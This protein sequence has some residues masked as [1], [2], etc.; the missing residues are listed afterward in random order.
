MAA[1]SAR[2]A[3]ARFVGGCVRDGLIGRPI[4][5][6]D[7]ATTDTP[8]TVLALLATAGIKA[9]PTGVEHGTV[10]AVIGATHVEITTLRHDVET[11]GR[12][13]RV[14]YTD[15]WEADA[16]RR[17]FTINALYADSDGTLYDPFG[18]ADDLREGRVRFVGTAEER[19]REDVLRLL[20]FFRFHAHYGR[21]APDPDGLAACRRLAH[22]LP[23]LSGERVAGEI[24]KILSAPD[25][26]A[27][28]TLMEETGVLVHIL[29]E[30]RALGRLATLGSI[31]DAV[32]AAGP[33][34]RLAVLIEGGTDAADAVATRLRL[35]NEQRA[36][37]VGMVETTPPI[38]RDLDRRH[39]RRILYRIGA[40][41]FRDRVLFAWADS[42]SR[43]ASA[44]E[45]DGWTRL[46]AEADAW[47]P[48][49]LPVKGRDVVALGVER[50]PE[51]GRL[52]EALESWWLDGDMRAG[53]E[54]ALAHLRSLVASSR[55]KGGR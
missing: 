27:I 10:T 44:S 7:L 36:R 3:T 39:V 29:P 22:L 38:H 2:G 11:F 4:G 33:L 17:D 41:R 53:R 46:L 45:T 32:G 5:D 19:I 20:R 30:A 6:V 13:A 25:V 16:A 1:L 55:G 12:R 49:E 34:R 48:L 42:V 21:G 23:S 26:H 47:R 51:V 52:L 8:E 35:S 15:D 50:G 14:A 18:G 37:F 40:E 43:G 24:F 9:I 31:E 28:V 54:E